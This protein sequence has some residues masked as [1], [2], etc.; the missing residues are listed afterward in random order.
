MMNDEV[1]TFQA[2]AIVVRIKRDIQRV[3]EILVGVL[4]NTTLRYQ[5]QY[6][7]A[8]LQRQINVLQ[9][10]VPMQTITDDDSKSFLGTRFPYTEKL[11]QQTIASILGTLSGLQH[12]EQDSLDDLA[13]RIVDDKTKELFREL[14]QVELSQQQKVLT[15]LDLIKKYRDYL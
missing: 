13:S 9:S 5:Y 11:K 7:H 12:E 15:D 14:S 8:E 4:K 1:Q 2:V 6:L 10:L 3:I